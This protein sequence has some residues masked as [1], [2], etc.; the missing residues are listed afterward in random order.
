M[1]GTRALA[2]GAMEA[3]E[4]VRIGVMSA[5]DQPGRENARLRVMSPQGTTTVCV[6]LGESVAIDGVG[7][8]TLDGLTLHHRAEGDRPART[9]RGRVDVA[10]EPIAVGTDK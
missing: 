6:G 8:V 4:D 1:D 5:N 9:G 7:T 10:F 2:M 3:W